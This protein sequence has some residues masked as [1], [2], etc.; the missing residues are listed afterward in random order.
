M[1][2]L[3]DQSFILW[4]LNFLFGFKLLKLQVSLISQLL[5]S[6]AMAYITLSLIL[7]ELFDFSILFSL[8]ILDSL[9]CLILQDHTFIMV[10]FY[11]FKLGLLIFFDLFLCEF[12]VFS[13]QLFNFGSILVDQ[14]F[15]IITMF[16]IYI[17]QIL[18]MFIF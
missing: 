6:L 12:G 15:C 11:K 2:K 16:L 1:L 10:V 17:L 9:S 8:N 13:D 18:I 14:V 7:L 4:P 5:E 3:V